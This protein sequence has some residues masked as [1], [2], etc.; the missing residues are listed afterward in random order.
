MV[1]L[2]GSRYENLR[3]SDIEK[4]LPKPSYTF[5]ML[6]EYKGLT[7]EFDLAF[8]VGLDTFYDIKTWKQH[9][10]ILQTT[11]CIVSYRVGQ[12]VGLLYSFLNEL[13]Y[14]ENINKCW[15]NPKFGTGVQV[16][17]TAPVPYSST[18]IKNNIKA[19]LNVSK[20]LP[21]PVYEYIVDNCLYQTP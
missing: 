11:N 1:H 18:L 8:I 7:N 21:S 17:K 15:T 6:H 19:G 2:A 16:L 14:T 3:C 9:Y 5:Q 20:M 4:K 13:G 10:S 12:D